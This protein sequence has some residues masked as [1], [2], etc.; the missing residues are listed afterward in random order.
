ME[1]HRAPGLF[2]SM[3]AARGSNDQS[4]VCAVCSVCR[5]AGFTRAPVQS[6]RKKV[7]AH[8]NASA[9]ERPRPDPGGT[10]VVIPKTPAGDA[11]R[12]PAGEERDQGDRGRTKITPGVR[13]DIKALCPGSRNSKLE[14]PPA[15]ESF[16]T[17][18]DRVIAAAAPPNCRTTQRRSCGGPGGDAHGCDDEARRVQSDTDADCR[19]SRAG[20][21]RHDPRS[22]CR[23][24]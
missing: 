17:L 6:R 16:M 7:K 1:G 13:D 14:P 9:A 20:F 2:G 23:T 8:S 5:P 24:G 22:D 11:R 19:H 18:F 3:T 10:G 15:S 4:E 21:A 12:G